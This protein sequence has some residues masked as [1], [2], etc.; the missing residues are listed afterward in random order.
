L[1]GMQIV[2][3]GRLASMSR[4]EAEGRI[5]ELGG[6]A[7][8]SVGKKTRYLVAGEEPGSKLAQ[9]RELGTEILDESQFIKLL[10][11]EATSGETG[12]GEMS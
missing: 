7:G 10:E 5:K 4:S 2:V 6:S 1:S 12:S 8:S 9:A 3:T 11:G